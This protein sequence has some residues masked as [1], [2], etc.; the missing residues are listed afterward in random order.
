MKKNVMLFFFFLLA[1]INFGQTGISIQNLNPTTAVQIIERALHENGY[2]IQQFDRE[3]GLILTDWIVWNTLTISNRG[4]LQINVNNSS[5]YIEMVDRGYKSTE[6]WSMSFGDLSK[7]N[8]KLFYSDL[9][10]R[11]SEINASDQLTIQAVQ[12][13]RLI[14]NFKPKILFHGLE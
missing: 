3:R 13:S 12:N 2:Q 9:A 4:R 1:Q 10:K 14:L 6:G 7:K 8:S 5:A 11:I